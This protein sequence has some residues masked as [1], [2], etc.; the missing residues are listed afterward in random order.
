MGARA[1][2]VLSQTLE[3]FA[4][5]DYHDVG[6]NFDSASSAKGGRALVEGTRIIFH[7]IGDAVL[8]DEI[9]QKRGM[10]SKNCH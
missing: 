9:I 7:G 1:E 4:L 6:Q 5:S 10:G 2:M 8:A 3:A